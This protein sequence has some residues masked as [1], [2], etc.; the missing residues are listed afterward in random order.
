MK[1]IIR[2]INNL[3]FSLLQACFD[4]ICT[5]TEKV[6]P[7]DIDRPA[8]SPSSATDRYWW[9]RLG[10]CLIMLLAGIVGLVALMGGLS[11]EKMEDEEDSDY[12]DD[13]DV[14]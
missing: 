9:L 8:S 4:L 6:L 13:S 2:T 5:M 11:A 14:D 10:A 12:E 3:I 1:L 7:K